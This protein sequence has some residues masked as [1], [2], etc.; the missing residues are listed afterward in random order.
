MTREEATGI[1]YC[2][3]PEALYAPGA[4]DDFFTLH[5]PQSTEALCAELAR[6]AYCDFS[7]VLEA[8]LPRAGFRLAAEPFERGGTQ[9]FLAESADR[10]VLVFRGS[11][12]ALDWLNNLNVMPVRW[13]GKG[14]V[15]GGF[16]DSLEA[17]WGEV[18]DAV[19]SVKRPLLVTGHSL[20][21]A[22]A[23][24]AATLLPCQEFI[25]FGAPKIGDAEFQESAGTGRRYVNN[26]DIVCRLPLDIFPLSGVYRHVGTAYLI[27]RQGGVSRLTE[28]RGTGGIGL[29]LR[30]L[31]LN[32]RESGRR[33]RLP[34]LLMDH[35]PINY[36]SALP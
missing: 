4:I 18:M 5:E 3:R 20:G 26:Q 1:P 14:R 6:L 9:A 16:S 36:V 29:S 15:H 17:I 10:A 24:L 30:D 23:G 7:S 25:I 27:G 34:R 31:R 19:R 2:W 35:A 12:D 32:F 28:T 11:D 13:R 8:A 21:G 22:L 33:R